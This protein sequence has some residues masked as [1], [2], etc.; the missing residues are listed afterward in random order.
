MCYHL[1]RS[2]FAEK[3]PRNREV[4]DGDTP[5]KTPEPQSGLCYKRGTGGIPY[6]RY[7]SGDRLFRE[8]YP[9]SKIGKSEGVT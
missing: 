2:Y 8:A 9:R 7:E 1:S 6:F 3:L 5:E 4:R